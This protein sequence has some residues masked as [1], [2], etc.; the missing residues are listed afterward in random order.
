M[1]SIVLG[2]RPKEVEKRERSIS[3]VP[4]DHKAFDINSILGHSV[5]ERWRGERNRAVFVSGFTLPPYPGPVD[6]ILIVSIILSE[7]T[8]NQ[9]AISNL[10]PSQTPACI[11]YL[12]HFTKV[13]WN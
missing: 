7:H 6:L 9:Y 13:T 8:Y 1:E 12:P 3:R 4:G 11:F 5:Y 2:E 10:F